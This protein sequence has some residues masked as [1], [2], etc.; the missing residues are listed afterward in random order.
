MTHF[1]TRTVIG[2][3]LEFQGAWQALEPVM[4]QAPHHRPPVHP[5]LYVKP[6]NTWARAGDPVLLP[7]DVEEVEVGPALH[8]EERELSLKIPLH[9]F[10]PS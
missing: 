1:P 6:A 9:R 4:A 10:P 3:L 8:L 7:P 2:A 5:V